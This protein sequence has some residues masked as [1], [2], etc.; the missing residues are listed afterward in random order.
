MQIW[1]KIF[2]LV[3]RKRIRVLVFHYSAYMTGEQGP[4][5]LFGQRITVVYDTTDVMYDELTMLLDILIL[6]DLG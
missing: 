4:V 2:D 3:Y 5:I 6:G 1:L